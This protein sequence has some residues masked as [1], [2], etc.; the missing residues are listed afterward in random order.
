MNETEELTS[1]LVVNSIIDLPRLFMVFDRGCWKID[2]FHGLNSRQWGWSIPW[3][4]RALIG[5]QMEIIDFPLGENAP[6][7]V[8]V[9]SSNANKPWCRII[10][11]PNLSH[12]GIW[13]VLCHSLLVSHLITHHLALLSSPPWFPPMAKLSYFV[14]G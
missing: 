6:V 7:E 10:G 4:R 11:K 12:D 9:W 5:V 3:K 14:T 13:D 8:M 2:R 1:W